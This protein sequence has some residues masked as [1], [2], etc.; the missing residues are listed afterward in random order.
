MHILVARRQSS[1]TNRKACLQCI[2]LRN[3]KIYKSN[4]VTTAI[5]D[6]RFKT[7]LSKPKRKENDSRNRKQNDSRKRK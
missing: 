3:D 4:I 1:N 2:N 5:C 7:K 6:C